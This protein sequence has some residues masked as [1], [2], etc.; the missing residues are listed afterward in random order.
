MTQVVIPEWVQEQQ[1]REQLIE[2]HLD[3][4]H[5]LSKMVSAI[6]DRLD[7]VFIGERSPAHFGMVPCRRHGRRKNPPPTAASSHH[8]VGPDGC[9][10]EPHSGIYNL[11]LKADMEKKDIFAAYRNQ[12]EREQRARQKQ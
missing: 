8:I 7:I 2:R 4:G 6:D 3:S 12:L 11:L 1:F 5:T 9:Y 10:L